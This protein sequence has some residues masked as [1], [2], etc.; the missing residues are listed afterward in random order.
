MRRMFSENQLKNQIK[1]VK[2]D[3]TTLV[4]SD[5]HD[6]FVEGD[7]NIEEITGVSKDYGKWS[8]SGTH[9]M[10]VLAC[11][12]AD[13]T[14]IAGSTKYAEIELPKWIHDKIVP[15]FSSYVAVVPTGYYND[16]SSGQS[17]NI[18]LR[19]DSNNKVSLISNAITMTKERHFRCQIDLLI[20]ND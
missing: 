11:T 10:F 13:Q 4:D 8:L 19:K 16:D 20:D 2:K 17:A 3:I 12:L 9:L 15:T 1:E 5:G 18:L 14:A 7:I 6:R